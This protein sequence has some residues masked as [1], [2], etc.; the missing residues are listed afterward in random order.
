MVCLL[1]LCEFSLRAQLCSAPVGIKTLHIPFHNFTA[2]V[3][4][5]QQV[6]RSPLTALDIINDA[7]A[8]VYSISSISREKMPRNFDL[9]F[10]QLKAVLKELPNW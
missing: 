8:C 1:S 9:V 4:A 3:I 10:P 7:I 6:P 2:R 5:R